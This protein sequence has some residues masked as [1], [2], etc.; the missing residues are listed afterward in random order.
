VPNISTFLQH[1]VGYP[2][3]RLDLLYLIAGL[4]TVLV[5]RLIGTVVDR[6]GATRV[7]IAGTFVF[8]SALYF[9]F[10]R[11][12]SAEHVIWVFPLLMLSASLRGVPL[13]TLASRVPR[14]A[15]RARFMSAQSAVQ[16]LA[17]AIGAFAASMALADGA[18]GRLVGMEAVALTAMGIAL[19]VPWVSSFVEN[20]VR[21]RESAR[22]PG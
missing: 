8:V 22:A 4:A 5:T 6:F 19:F 20:G 3:E 2:R 13:N 11:P 12:L 10:V 7:I 18:G 14:A 17:S 16:H 15:E 9:G 1:N 21:Q